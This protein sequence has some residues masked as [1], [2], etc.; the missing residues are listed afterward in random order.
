[1][2]LDR[3]IRRTKIARYRNHNDYEEHLSRY[4]Y[5]EYLLCRELSGSI[6]RSEVFFPAEKWDDIFPGEEDQEDNGYR[7]EGG[8]D[9]EDSGGWGEGWMNQ[10]E[11]KDLAFLEEGIWK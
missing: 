9:P 7:E 4:F 10:Y 8:K 6:E 1:M 5:S 11:R 3:R 2:E